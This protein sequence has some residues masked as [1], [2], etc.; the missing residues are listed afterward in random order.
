[1]SLSFEMRGSGP[2]L[3]LAHGAGG[4]VMANFPFLENAGPWLAAIQDFL[5]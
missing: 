1:M 3:L 4:S 5:P 2:G